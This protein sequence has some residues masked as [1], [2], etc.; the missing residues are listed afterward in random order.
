M[1]KYND[2]NIYV[3]QI[4]ELLHSFN[5]PTCKI[6]KED[7]K[8]YEGE[9]YID[10]KL[11]GV[12]KVDSVDKNL[13]PTSAT[14]VK[15]YKFNDEILNVT[16]N[17]EIRNNYYDSYTHAY[18]GN[19]LRFLRDYLNI[20]LMSMYNC[21]TNESPTNMN[22]SIT[23]KAHADEE[24]L[25]NSNNDDY[26]IFMIPVKSNTTYTLAFEYGNSFS[27][28]YG[29]YSYNH[30]LNL[31]NS[32]ESDTL[33][34]FNDIHMR[35]PEIIKSP[36]LITEEQLKQEENLKLFIILPNSFTDNIVLLEGDYSKN[37]QFAINSN[38]TQTLTDEF[39]EYTQEKFNVVN[40]LWYFND[41]N[42]GVSAVDYPLVKSCN[43]NTST[44]RFDIEF[45]NLDDSQHAVA[46]S[47]KKIDGSNYDYVSRLQ[48]LEFAT[49]TKYLLAD[50]LKE[51]LSENVITS[52]DDII[53]NIKRVQ[54]IIAS[55][56]PNFKF[57]VYGVWSD[58]INKWLY[59]YISTHG[60]A[61]DLT[62]RDVYYDSLCFIDKDIETILNSF[63]KEFA[64]FG[65]SED[66]Y[67]KLTLEEKNA[68]TEKKNR[69]DN[70]L[71]LLNQLGGIYA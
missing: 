22:I 55:Y 67:N 29:F 63:V 62:Y 18:L 57:D 53:N 32:F 28:F 17:L 36:K 37:V 7:S 15:D 61:G 46:Y 31:S 33:T 64:T 49:Q 3:G 70:A 20:N 12:Y 54:V 51:Y 6:K 35:K 71:M 25:V 58:D 65:I 11:G 56:D 50:R 5:L 30:Y 27:I 9:Y 39:F 2:D 16:K 4:K 26:N 60:N 42:T 41:E 19:Y 24:Y 68:Y 43:F 14:L 69:Y 10:T 66:D 40:N 47:S 8:F 59:K 34:S 13:N 23:D 21:F 52:A 1:I 44:N 45:Q 48:L 38:L